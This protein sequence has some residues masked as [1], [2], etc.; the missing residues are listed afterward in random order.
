MPRLIIDKDIKP[1]SDF[2]THASSYVRQV[3]KTKRPVVITD[4]GKSAAVLLDASEYE[5]LLQ[6]AE[7]MDDIR[8]AEAQ[9]AQGNGVP[10]DAALKKVMGRVLR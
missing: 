2:R 10:H 1:L 3:R 6:K 9:I 8:G 5:G 7:V 4:R